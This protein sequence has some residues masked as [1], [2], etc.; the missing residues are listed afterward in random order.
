MPSKLLYRN[1]T[2]DGPTAKQLR[3]FMRKMGD[4]LDMVLDLADADTMGNLPFRGL[5]KTREAIA[6]MLAVSTVEAPVVSVLDG[7]D[8][9]QLGLKGKEIAEAKAFLIEKA[10]E[11]AAENVELT[12]VMAKK[13]IEE[14]SN[15]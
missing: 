3:K 12:P 2:G 11:F 14:R 1:N 5:P 8:L 13:L 4:D 9:M 15:E 6:E 10:D 7:Y